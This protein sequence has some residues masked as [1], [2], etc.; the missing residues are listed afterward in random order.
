MSVRGDNGPKCPVCGH[1]E[2]DTEAWCDVVTWWG[3]E[4]P[5]EFHCNGCGATFLVKE[6]VSRHW[7][8][9]MPEETQ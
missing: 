6:H 9:T 5:V 8:S 7:E 2:V 3:D 1:E 4:A